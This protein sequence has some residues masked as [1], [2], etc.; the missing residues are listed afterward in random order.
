MPEILETVPDSI[1][2]KTQTHCIQGFVA[3]AKYIFINNYIFECVDPDCF[4][5]N[6]QDGDT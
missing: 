6:N 5:C 3:Y 1:K 2:E 4:P